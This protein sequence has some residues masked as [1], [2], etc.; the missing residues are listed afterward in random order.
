MKTFPWCDRSGRFS[1]LKAATFAGLWLP[2][3]V[4]AIDLLDGSFAEKMA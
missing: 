4:A 1:P 3:L 2:A